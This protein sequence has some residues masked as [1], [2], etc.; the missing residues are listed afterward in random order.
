FP[1][2]FYTPTPDTT[3]EWMIFDSANGSTAALTVTFITPITNPKLH[4][5]NMDASFVDVGATVT[6]GGG[7]VA[8]SRINGNNEFEVVGAEVNNTTRAAINGGCEANDNTNGEGACGTIQLTGTYQNIRFSVVN[9]AAGGDGF[10]LTI[11]ENTAVATATPVPTLSEWM[12]ILLSIMLGFFAAIK[13]K[14]QRE[15]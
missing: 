12:L 11:S 2:T 4:F 10:G 1:D 14:A 13:I 7:A 15:M 3:C 9:Q 8:I 6:T 5:Y